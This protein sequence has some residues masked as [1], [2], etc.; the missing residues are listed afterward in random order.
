MI[1]NIKKVLLTA[2]INAARSLDSAGARWYARLDTLAWVPAV[3][4]KLCAHLRS[5][6]A[7][8]EA[9]AERVAPRLGVDMVADVLEPLIDRTC[10]A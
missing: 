1:T 6:G 8:L 9:F 5:T 7:A 2:A 3:L 4:W 10:R